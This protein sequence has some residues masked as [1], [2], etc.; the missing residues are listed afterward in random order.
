MNPESEGI[1]F[2]NSGPVSG[3]YT[4]GFCKDDIYLRV[5]YDGGMNVTTYG[6]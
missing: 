6:Y 5:R 2:M 4:F 1:D 3:I